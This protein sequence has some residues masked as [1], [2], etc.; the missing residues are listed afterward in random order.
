M[1]LNH[2]GAKVLNLTKILGES[3]RK[4]KEF[5]EAILYYDKIL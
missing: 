4:L 3:L 2:Y 1:M 5:K